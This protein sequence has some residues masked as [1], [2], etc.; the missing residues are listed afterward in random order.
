MNSQQA[1][2]RIRRGVARFQAEVYPG[3]RAMFEALAHSQDP[4]ALFITCTDS[5]IVPNLITQTGP[6]ELFVERNPGNLVPRHADLVV[7]VS[8]SVEYALLALKVPL[9]IICGHTD[10]GVMKG[11]LRPETVERLPAIRE[12]MGHARGVREQVRGKY[13]DRAEEDQLFLI[14]QHN[15]LVQ[16]ENLKTYPSVQAR[17]DAGELEIRGWV[18]DIVTGAC[19]SVNP[20]LGKFEVLGAKDNS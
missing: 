20:A 10:C 2:E 9:V 7:N 1:I 18:Y 3:Q 13:S 16:I 11:L 6:G 5:R 14:T 19:W 12:W 4:I 17:L 15:I 8:A